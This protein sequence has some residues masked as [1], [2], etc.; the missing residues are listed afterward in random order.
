MSDESIP[1]WDRL[2]GAADRAAARGDWKQA[3]ELAY[4][5]R[6]AWLNHCENVETEQEAK[7]R[8]GWYRK[9][10]ADWEYEQELERGRGR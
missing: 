1:V 10:L 8:A 5:A 6:E 4:A 2:S 3:T 7:R 9:A